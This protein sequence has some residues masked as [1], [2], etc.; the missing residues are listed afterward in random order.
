VSLK[1]LCLVV[2]RTIIFPRILNYLCF[3]VVEPAAL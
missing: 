2:L 3:S 1:P